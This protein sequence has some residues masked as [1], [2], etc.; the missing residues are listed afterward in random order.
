MTIREGEASH[1]CES[2]RAETGRHRC[3]L[4]ILRGSRYLSKIDLRSGYHQPRVHKDDILK[5]E[6]RTRYGH[7][8][9]TVMPFGMTNAPATKEEHEI[10]LGL[11]LDLLK[12]EKLY[13][14]FSK[15]EFWLQEVQ[16]VGHVVNSDGIHVDLDKIK[17][18]KDWEALKS[19]TKVHSFL[20]NEQ[21]T[22]F[23][24]L[25]DKLCNSH[26][27]ALPD[28][29][30]DFMVIMDRLTKSSHFLPIREDFKMDRLPRLY[31]NKIV[32]RHGVPI[33]IISDR[34]SRFTSRF[35]KSMQDALGTR[36]DMS[37]YGLPPHRLMV[38]AGVPFR[39]WKTRSRH[40][41]STSKEVGTFIFHW[42]NSPKSYAGKQ[43]KLLEFSMDDHV[44]L[45]VSPLKGV[46][47]FGKKGKLAPSVHDMFY[48]SNLKKCLADPTPHVPLEEIQVYAKL[49]FVEE[50][51]EILEREIK[52]LKRS[53]IPIVKMK[54]ALRETLEE[55]T[56]AE[57]EL[58]ERIKQEQAH[59]ELFKLEFE[60]PLSVTKDRLIRSIDVEESVK[61][62]TTVFQP[63]KGEAET[64]L[65][66]QVAEEVTLAKIAIDF[67]WCELHHDQDKAF[68]YFERLV[69][70]AQADR[71][72]RV[73]DWR[74]F[75]DHE[76]EKLRS[77]MKKCLKN[78]DQLEEK[79][80][81]NEACESSRV[82][83]NRVD[84]G[85]SKLKVQL[86]KV[87]VEKKESKKDL[88]KEKAKADSEKK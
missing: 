82:D 22:K 65:D 23:Q 74:S 33:S 41:S 75:A 58:E 14:N 17:A 88:Q 85:L 45:K 9:F 46:V 81:A 24:T 13:A 53:R 20:G 57:K 21:E 54:E 61:N 79:R 84:Q 55:E 29:L 27:L 7:F 69:E 70:V 28:G 38:K 44:L 56:I 49:N 37:T 52:K 72:Q 59:D 1:E 83:R 67:S 51:V 76:K 31:L 60:I 12:K 73:T 71:S 40:A 39:S 42:L 68:T 35:W 34:D 8:E 6:F 87:E 10:H 15:C 18:V 66:M 36:L 16:F 63:E 86:L 48:V 2:K 50:P 19:P 4:K 77:M 62:G 25:K 64:Q 3:H 11:I 47:C 43:R 78:K 5:T 30:E 80:R 32:A 26:V